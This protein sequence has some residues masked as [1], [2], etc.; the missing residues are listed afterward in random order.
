MLLQDRLEVPGVLS[1]WRFM[2]K[3]KPARTRTSHLAPGV[4]PISSSAASHRDNAQRGCLR[5]SAVR[6]AAL[7]RPVVRRP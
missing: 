2:L 5:W 4:F 1:M 3:W 6:F 7:R